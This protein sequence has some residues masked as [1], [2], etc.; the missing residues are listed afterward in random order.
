MIALLRKDFY[1][2]RKKL[3]IL[4][5]IIGCVIGFTLFSKNTSS[6]FFALTYLAGINASI[7][8]ISISLDE[9]NNGYAALFTLPILRKQYIQSKYIGSILLGF[10]VL[11]IMSLVSLIAFSLSTDGF[12]LTEWLFEIFFAYGIFFIMTGIIIPVILKVGVEHSKLYLMIIYICIA[13]IGFLGYKILKSSVF[14]DFNSLLEIFNR[15]PDLF[16]IVLFL[17]SA[18][19]FLFSYLIS[20]KIFE[21]K[22]F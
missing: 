12:I 6:S 3:K 16:S 18:L 8:S 11:S 14:I 10:I 15:F 4:L 22:E 20:L 1:L 5:L 21:Q 19:F 17:F 7:S 9:S 2:T 13:G